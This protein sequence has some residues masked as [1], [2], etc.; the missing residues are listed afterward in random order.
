MTKSEK[1]YM[2]R[3][4]ECGCSLCHIL[5]CEGDTP[6]NLHHVRE[7]QGMGQK[8]QNWLVV[9]LCPTCHQG[10]HGIHGDRALL[11]LAKVNEM[12][13]LAWTIEKLNA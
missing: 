3:V 12:D 10:Q 13:L 1:K 8:A 2:N 7:G 5:G 4:A 9:P 11:K 6:V